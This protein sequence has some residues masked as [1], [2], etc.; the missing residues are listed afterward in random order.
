MDLPTRFDLTI[1]LAQLHL[2]SGIIDHN[3]FKFFTC[4]AKS[5]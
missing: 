3:I 2:R 4:C 5:S 1:Q